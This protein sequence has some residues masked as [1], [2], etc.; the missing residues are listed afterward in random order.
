MTKIEAFTEFSRTVL[1][2]KV[3]SFIEG[4]TG[5]KVRYTMGWLDETAVI[6]WDG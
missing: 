5:V 4:K 2:R 6:E 1:L 3:N